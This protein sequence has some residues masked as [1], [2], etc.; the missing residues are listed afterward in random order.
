MMNR[1]RT[2]IQNFQKLL[3]GNQSFVRQ[4]SSVIETKVNL[5]SKIGSSIA[6][7]YL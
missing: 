1:S 5:S 6:Q 7:K 2:S 4:W 3:R